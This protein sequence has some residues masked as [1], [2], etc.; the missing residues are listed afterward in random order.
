MPFHHLQINS[1]TLTALSCD[2]GAFGAPGK[3][4]PPTTSGD[5]KLIAFD[6]EEQIDKCAEYL[7]LRR[8]SLTEHGRKAKKC[9]Q[10]QAVEWSTSPY[11]CCKPHDG[12][13]SLP[14]ETDQMSRLGSDHL[15]RADLSDQQDG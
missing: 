11:L 12:A 4:S 7:S 5:I 9:G 2:Y 3:G 8:F 10:Q 13:S 6:N 1:G 15:L 14:I